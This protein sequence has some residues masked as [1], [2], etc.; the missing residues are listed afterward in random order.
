MAA[1]LPALFLSHGAPTLALGRSPA[2]RFLRGLPA[3]LPARPAAILVA[4]AHWET[5]GPRLT[6]ASRNGTIHDFYGFPQPLYDLRYEAPGAPEIARRAAALLAAEGF[7]PAL[8]GTRGLDHGAWVPLILAWPEAD[9]PVL[10]LSLQTAL[11]PRHHWALGR[12]LAPLSDEGVLIVGSG[13]WTHDLSSFR[14]QAEDAPEPDWVKRF[15]DWAEAALLEDR[16]DD[17]LAY[18]ERAPEAVANHPT[19]EHFLPIFVAQGAGGGPARRLHR[20]ATYGIL[21]MA[22]Y[23]IGGMA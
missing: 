12:A 7:E 1:T 16:L 18:R 2:A 22:A 6:A 20:S 5:A 3:L 11:G 4:S 10:Q 8:D 15:A 21:D 14:G 9:I 17:L 23:A 13:S 19:E